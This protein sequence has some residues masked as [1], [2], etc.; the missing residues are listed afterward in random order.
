VWEEMK[1]VDEKDE[2]N[3]EEEKIWIQVLHEL[4]EAEMKVVDEKD[5]YNHEEEKIWIQ[6]LHEL[7][8]AEMKE[9]V[10]LVIILVQIIELNL[11]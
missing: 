9:G 1:V 4:M 7:M 2:Y 8:E 6:V 5:E 3:H 11:D 10:L